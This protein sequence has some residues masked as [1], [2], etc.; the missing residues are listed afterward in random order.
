MS[1]GIPHWLIA[2]TVSVFPICKAFLY[3]IK[4]K[5]SDYYF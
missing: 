1:K 3:K 5:D 2:E 4:E